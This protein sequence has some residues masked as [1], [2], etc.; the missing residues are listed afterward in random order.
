MMVI[1]SVVMTNIRYIHGYEEKLR[2]EKRKA[3]AV[4]KQMEEAIKSVFNS[5]GCFLRRGLL[6]KLD[7]EM[8]AVRL[9]IRVISADS[10][11]KTDELHKLKASWQIL[12]WKFNAL[13]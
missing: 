6:R 9:P 5:F 7:L 8:A 13:K 11:N 12:I 4:Q 10:I 3:R 1:A 2:E